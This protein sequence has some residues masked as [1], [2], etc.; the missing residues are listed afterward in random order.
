MAQRYLRA[1]ASPPRSKDWKEQNESSLYTDHNDA[2]FR[3]G[4]ILHLKGHWHAAKPRT[5]NDDSSH[6]L[7]LTHYCRHF[8]PLTLYL[9]TWQSNDISHV[10][11]NN[12]TGLPL[13]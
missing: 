1:S 4:Q 7:Y 8:Q 13:S 12:T 11:V 6:A 10:P 2:I 3:A 9:L 5:D